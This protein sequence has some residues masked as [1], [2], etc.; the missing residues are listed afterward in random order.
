MRVHAQHP[1]KPEGKKGHASDRARSREAVQRYGPLGHREKGEAEHGQRDG[2][3][4]VLRL[5]KIEGD[6]FGHAEVGRVD[7]APLRQ[8]PREKDEHPCKS[9]R[10]DKPDVDAVGAI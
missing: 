4:Y 6:Q 5:E 9:G 10:K 3:W 7:E 8:Q 1:R 2:D